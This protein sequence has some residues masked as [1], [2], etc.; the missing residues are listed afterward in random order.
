[1]VKKCHGERW[2]CKSKKWT[3][4]TA[5]PTSTE[6]TSPETSFALS[7]RSGTLWLRLTF[8]SK[9]QMDTSSDCSALDS[10]KEP[11]DKLRLLATPRTHRRNSLDKRWWRS[12]FQR[13]KNLPSRSSPRN[14]M[15]YFLWLLSFFFQYLFKIINLI[16]YSVQESISKQIQKECGKIFPLQNVLIR[17]VKMLKK[18]K[19]DLT[20]LMENY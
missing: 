11:R 12:W 10:L 9:L 2:R 17:K 20:R 14:C 19:F 15:Y 6:W 4:T 3:D 1:M 16:S 18:P 5:T 13:S 8:K 7:W